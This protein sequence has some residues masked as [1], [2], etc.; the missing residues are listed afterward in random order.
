MLKKKSSFIQL[1]HLKQQKFSD[2][3]ILEILKI[4]FV[5]TE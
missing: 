5:L 3:K 1:P 4:V 2:G